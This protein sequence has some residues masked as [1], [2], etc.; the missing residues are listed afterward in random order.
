[1]TSV[2]LAVYYIY[3][4]Q[5]FEYVASFGWNSIK[6]KK[7]GMVSRKHALLVVWYILT[8]VSGVHIINWNINKG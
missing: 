8:H 2:K 4:Y 5:I 7:I 6:I 1:M 3:G